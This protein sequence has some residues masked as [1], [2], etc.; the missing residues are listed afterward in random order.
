MS[1][2]QSWLEFAPLLLICVLVVALGFGGLN[3][4]RSD[5]ADSNGMRL[6]RLA[7][8]ELTLASL[9]DKARFY[10]NNAPRDYDAYFRDSEMTQQHLK[11]DL[12]LVDKLIAG[13]INPI[14]NDADVEQTLGTALNQVS[15]AWTDF[16]AGLG[17]QLGVDPEMP[18][19]EWGMRHIDEQLGGVN[20][21]AATLRPLLVERAPAT[22]RAPPIWAWPALIAWLV[23]ML[24]WYAW[25]GSRRQG[26][27]TGREQSAVE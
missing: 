27:V 2:K 7:D 20:N 14:G 13:L 22:T 9:H 12:E 11:S 25:R 1:N 8:I 19:L 6:A 4:N 15:R 24:G 3:G 17:E 16:R 21:A 23:V 26:A 10:V 5:P 18:R